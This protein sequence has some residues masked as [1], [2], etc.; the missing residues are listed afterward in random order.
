MAAILTSMR[1]EHT[2]A[3]R[4][5]PLPKLVVE[6]TPPISDHPCIAK[7][8]LIFADLDRLMPIRLGTLRA[9]GL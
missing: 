5:V 8:K 7:W 1:T 2:A 6:Q 9:A 3:A 4:V